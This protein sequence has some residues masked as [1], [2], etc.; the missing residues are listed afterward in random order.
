MVGRA[1]LGLFE[2]QSINSEASG[3]RTTGTVDFFNPSQ[4]DEDAFDVVVAP[5]LVDD[6]DL[7]WKSA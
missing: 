5:P 1:P 4:K 7:N 2:K 3:G 6:L